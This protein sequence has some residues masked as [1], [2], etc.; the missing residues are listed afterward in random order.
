MARL[1]WFVVSAP[2]RGWST[3]VSASSGALTPKRGCSSTCALQTQEARR[4]DMGAVLS[5]LIAQ[6]DI[7]LSYR[8]CY[9]SS[10]AIR[11]KGAWA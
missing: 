9:S 10:E 8:L 1:N 7:A 11:P 2:K 5:E 4:L 3:D 6:H